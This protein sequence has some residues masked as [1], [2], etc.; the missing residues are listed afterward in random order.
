[1]ANISVIDAAFTGL[2]VVRRNPGAVI[3]W[4]ILHLLSVAF[5]TWLAVVKFHDLFASIQAMPHVQAQT[6]P[7]AA[8]AQLH[9]MLPVLH[10]ILPLYGYL[11]P[12]G[13]VLA[14]IFISAMNRA[15]LRPRD[16]A[17]G[18]LRLGLD[19][20]RQLVLMI[21]FVVVQILVEIVLV[22]LAFIA[23]FVAKT[24]MHSAAP[25]A[26]AHLSMVIGVVVFCVGLILFEVKMSL[27]S[28]QTFA[29]RQINVFGSWSLT[30]GQF[31]PMI[32]TYILAFILY[33]I[34]AII[35]AIIMAV[36]G[37]LTAGLGGMGHAGV[38]HVASFHMGAFHMAGLHTVTMTSNVPPSVFTPKGLPDWHALAQFLTPAVVIQ[39]VLN[40]VLIAILLPI[41]LTPPAAI[42]KALTSEANGSRGSGGVLNMS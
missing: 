3:A 12:F 6:D 1:M 13:L 27:A 41:L 16:S 36:V 35:L 17:L 40:S 26:S 42:Y 39:L 2:R 38:A 15:V 33:I 25:G 19:E 28:A 8:Q 20:I 34:V 32:A 29:T 5:V 22:V 14:A 23:A 21:A 9:Q 10:Q 37:M 24:V 7:T 11:L 30:N 4:A 31:L 18:F